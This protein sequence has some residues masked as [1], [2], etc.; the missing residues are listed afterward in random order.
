MNFELQFTDKQITPWGGLSLL[1]RMLEHLGFDTALAASQ[2]PQPGSNRGY[3][4][5]QLMMQFMLG[6]WCGANRFEHG[7]VTRH[8]TVLQR[9]FG[10]ARM[11]NFKAVIRLFSKFD[12]RTNDRVFGAL[13]AWLFGQLQIDGL[14]LD[15][16]STVMTRYGTQ[17]GAVRGY[18]PA[19][20]GRHSHHPLIAFVADTRMVANLWLRPGN[21]HTANNALAFLQASL[22][23]LDGKRVELL[24]ADSGFGDDGFLT[25]LEQRKLHYIVAARLQQPVQRALVAQTGWWTL[26]E[27]IELVSFDYQSP[28]WASPRRMVGIRQHIRHRASAKGKTLSLFADDPAQG[29]Y[30]YGALITDLAL[31]AQQIW[32]TYRGRADCENRIKEL[33]YDFA[34]DSFCLTDFFAT[35]ACLNTVMLAYNL[36]SVFRQA[37]LKASVMQSRGKDV[38]HTLK[39][40]RFK[41]FAKAGYLTYE[42]RK[43]ILKL[44][45]AMR[46]RQWFEGVWDQSKHFDLPVTFSPVFSP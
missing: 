3:P 8:D 45:V 17:E 6:V 39:T 42:G 7:E 34:A 46:Q 41:L 43:N 10:F 11:A 38:Q 15:L 26:D 2:L 29:V 33:K 16:D 44:A 40:L 12:Q 22:D 23:R 28:S 4:P 20:P 18:N 27:G 37:A 25:D 35:E 9:L 13:Y 31:P 19:K 1:K 21:S 5:E 24:R 14:T 32:R 30:R 36:M